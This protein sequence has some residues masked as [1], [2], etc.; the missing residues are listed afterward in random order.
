MGEIVKDREAETDMK[1]KRVEQRWYTAVTAVTGSEFTI[2]PE[3]VR[4]KGVIDSPVPTAVSGG[5]ILGNCS[6][7]A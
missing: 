4:D 1:R 7:R 5:G 6:S 2:S 3:E